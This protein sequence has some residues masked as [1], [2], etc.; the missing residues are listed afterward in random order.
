[1]K[2]IHYI[3]IIVTLH[4]CCEWIMLHPRMFNYD[5][6]VSNELNPQYC[7]DHPIIDSILTLY[8]NTKPIYI[9]SGFVINGHSVIGSMEGGSRNIFFHDIDN[10]KNCKK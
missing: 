10:C 4:L 2:N 8:T 1:M 3:T 7:K 9:R 5:E 6:K